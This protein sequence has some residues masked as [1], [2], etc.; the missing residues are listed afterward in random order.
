MI[1]SLMLQFVP[2]M[3]GA[4]GEAVMFSVVMELRNGTEHVQDVNQAQTERHRPAANNHAVR[5][6]INI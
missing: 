2:V 6:K 4:L 3:P 1:K 5:F